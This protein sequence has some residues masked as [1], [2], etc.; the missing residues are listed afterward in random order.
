MKKI[1]KGKEPVAWVQHRCTSGAVYEAI[2]DL[3]AALLAEQGYICAY[4]MCRIS[5]TQSRI[6]H[7]LSRKQYPEKQMDYDNMVIC[8]NGETDGEAHCDRSKKDNSVS[9]DLQDANFIDSISYSSKT[10]EI[11]C[12]QASHQS[13]MVDYLN[14]NHARLKANRRATLEGII[15]E[16][17]KKRWATSLKKML[18]IWE[19]KDDQGRYHPYCGIVIYYLK[20]KLRQL[21]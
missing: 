4:C 19:D 16:C 7:V 6:E 10:G 11:R 21:P 13:E 20:K 2:P 8:C 14:L 1:T 17:N 18:E 12:S 3:R 15:E 5:S 9:F